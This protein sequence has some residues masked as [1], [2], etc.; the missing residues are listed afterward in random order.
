MT[1]VNVE[2]DR[3]FHTYARCTG[4]VLL[5]DQPGNPADCAAEPDADWTGGA[6][7]RRSCATYQH[8]GAEADEASVGRPGPTSNW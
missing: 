5:W 1:T 8:G 6:V 2:R 3:A 4:P 7:R